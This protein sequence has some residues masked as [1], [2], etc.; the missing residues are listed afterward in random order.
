M[1]LNSKKL[2]TIL[3]P[4]DEPSGDIFTVYSC[5]QIKI[6]KIYSEHLQGASIILSEWRLKIR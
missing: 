6:R 4:W 1:L 5:Y 2:W 3:I